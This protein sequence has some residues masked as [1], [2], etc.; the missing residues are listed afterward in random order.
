[1]ATVNISFPSGVSTYVVDAA[2][3]EG[4]ELFFSGR[5]MYKVVECKVDYA[6][7]YLNAYGGWDT[8]GFMQGKRTDNFTQFDY[9]KAYNNQTLEFGRKRQITEITPSWELTSGWLKED[10]AE[11]FA[12]HLIPTGQAYLQDIAAGKWYPVIITDTKAEYKNQRYS[13]ALINYTLKVQASQDR[14]RR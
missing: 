4:M 3:F 11:R 13:N 14:P 7:V 10:E 6:L 12:K 5:S 8:F 2:D 9:S 1:M